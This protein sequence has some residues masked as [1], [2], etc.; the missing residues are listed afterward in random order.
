MEEEIYKPLQE[1]ES[2]SITLKSRVSDLSGNDIAIAFTTWQI[3][4]WDQVRTKR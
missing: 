1:Q 3:K 2:I 4:P